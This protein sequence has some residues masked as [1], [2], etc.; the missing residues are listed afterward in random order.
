M[1]TS[2]VIVI[3]Y[4]FAAT[5]HVMATAA[6]PASLA[7]ATAPL[8]MPLLVG[9]VIFGA[10]E[11]GQRPT[12]W[13]LAGLFLAT[14]A[15][16]TSLAGPAAVRLIVL[17]ASLA[18]YAIAAVTARRWAGLEWGL[19]FVLLMLS[20]ALL[21]ARLSDPLSL[22]VPAVLPTLAYVVGQVLVVTGWTRR[23]M[24]T[25]RVPRPRT[26]IG[27]FTRR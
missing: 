7:W 12:R 20:G 27:A 3:L 23:S 22:S 2:R 8:L 11:T 24:G 26:P 25:P 19:G 14:A 15:D 6:G 18:C 16:V 4:A 21:A 5:A 10:T 17:V 9:V 1:P 13:L